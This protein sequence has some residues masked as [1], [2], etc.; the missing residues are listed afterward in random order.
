MP[1]LARSIWLGSASFWSCRN[2]T[3]PARG[4]CGAV[5]L[6]G[7]SISL[8]PAFGTQ[9]LNFSASQVTSQG[10]LESTWIVN[11]GEGVLHTA[12]YMHPTANVV[13]TQ[14]LWT[15]EN[16]SVPQFLNVNVS[17]W[18]LGENAGAHAGPMPT[19]AGCVDYAN[20]TPAPCSVGGVAAAVSRA[21]SNTTRGGGGPRPVWAGISTIVSP[22][23]V[24]ADWV[25]APGGAAAWATTAV[26]AIPP[27]QLNPPVYLITAEAEAGSYT[28]PDPS[29][30]AAALAA[31]FAGPDGP[32][33][34]AA[35]ASA[36]WADFWARSSVSI[37]EESDPV[38][39]P[40][41]MWW[42]AQV[43]NSFPPTVTAREAFSPIPRAHLAA[44]TV[45]SRL[46]RQL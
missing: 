6:G 20:G 29:V 25:A 4:C 12:T 36:W 40:E 32:Q 38:T 37:G 3:T 13:V 45:R 27:S 9:P 14:L 46:H 26:I 35:A 5:A 18:V 2:C 11:G 21:A 39:L 16:P 10:I 34:V 23:T 17:T 22:A 30:A 24:S 31:R 8:Q 33:A 42:G 7:I 28:G 41:A 43:W 1:S 19:F 15:P 44:F